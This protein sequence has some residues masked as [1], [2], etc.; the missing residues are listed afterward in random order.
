[1][2]F[3]KKQTFVVFREIRGRLVQICNQIELFFLIFL[4]PDKRDELLKQSFKYFF[5]IILVFFFQ[6]LGQRNDSFEIL[7]VFEEMFMFYIQIFL[8]LLRIFKVEIKIYEKVLEIDESF[9][10]V[11]FYVKSRSYKSLYI[12]A[13]FFRSEIIFLYSIFQIF[14]IM[15]KN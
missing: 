4:S 8:I 14:D 2:K 13:A 7:M 5:K 11:A 15:L 3:H 1:M 9:A 6:F 10:F 12:V